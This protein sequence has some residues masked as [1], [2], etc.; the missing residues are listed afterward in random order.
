MKEKR[1]LTTA[2][3]ARELGVKPA[4]VHRAYCVRG[5]YMGIRPVKLPNRR[6]LWPVSE[7]EAL[8]NGERALKE[9]AA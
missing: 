2:E 1:N 4:T 5:H 6:L 3:L 9:P 8:L 7:V